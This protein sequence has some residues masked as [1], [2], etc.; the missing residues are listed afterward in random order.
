MTTTA[1]ELVSYKLKTNVPTE[2]L[3]EVNAAVNDFLQ[4]QEG[5]YYRSMSQDDNGTYFDIVYWKDMQHAQNASDAFMQNPSC[6][7]LM[8]ITDMDSIKM[9]HMTAISES[10][11]CEQT[12]EA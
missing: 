2:Q 8:A 10:M 6:Q 4:A 3:A 5:F 7:A 9:R 11:M 12:A 1:I